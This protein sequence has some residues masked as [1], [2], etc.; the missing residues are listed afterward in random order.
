MWITGGPTDG[1]SVIEYPDWAEADHF[2][3]I[4]PA[5]FDLTPEERDRLL[6]CM[7]EEVRDLVTA[8]FWTVGRYSDVAE[9]TRDN[10]DLE[11]GNVTYASKKGRLKKLKKRS[12]PL[13]G[14]MPGIIARR[15][16]AWEDAS[17]V[18]GKRSPYVF[19]DETG[20][21]WTNSR[22]NRPWH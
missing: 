20:R 12:V 15:R 9:L 13:M 4:L 5:A 10:V 6:A 21:P 7:S 3:G 1:T 8:L 2:P 16:Q 17:R 18:G 19:A 14:P 22:F 11:K